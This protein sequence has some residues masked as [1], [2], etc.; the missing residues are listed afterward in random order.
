MSNR[1]TRF[2]LALPTLFSGRPSVRPSIHPSTDLALGDSQLASTDV[3]VVV[4]AAIVI[5]IIIIRLPVLFCCG[6]IVGNRKWQ[7]ETNDQ[8]R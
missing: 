8:V 2:Q 7:Q 5:I 4:V 3:V 6:E 1:N